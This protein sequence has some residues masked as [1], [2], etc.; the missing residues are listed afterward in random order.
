MRPE[1]GWVRTYRP[2]HKADTMTAAGHIAKA[3][4]DIDGEP[5]RNDWITAVI[6]VLGVGGERSTG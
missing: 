1:G 2:H 4:R 5:G 3:M 6:D